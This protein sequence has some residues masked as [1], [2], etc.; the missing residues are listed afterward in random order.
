MDEPTMD[1]RTVDDLVGQLRRYADAAQQQVPTAEQVPPPRIRRSTR[2]VLAAA[3]AVA[4]VAGATGTYLATSDDQQLRTTPPADDVA[5][6]GPIYDG[7]EDTCPPVRDEGPRIDDLQLMLPLVSSADLTRSDASG[8]EL[9]VE[10]DQGPETVVRATVLAEPRT[11]GRPPEVVVPGDTTDTTV[12][13]CD[14]FDGSGGRPG[15]PAV[16]VQSEGM[17]QLVFELGG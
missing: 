14:P 13:T 5:P 7:L 16:L 4:L 3:A 2:R 15:V 12:W 10:R 17:R 9:V 8:V 6:P 1:E 11:P